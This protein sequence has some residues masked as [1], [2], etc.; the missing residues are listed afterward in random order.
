VRFTIQDHT[1]K[2]AS[3]API[4]NRAIDWTWKIVLK[5]THAKFETLSKDGLFTAI[6]EVVNG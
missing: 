6:M 2:S 5:G 1:G 4:E 3:P